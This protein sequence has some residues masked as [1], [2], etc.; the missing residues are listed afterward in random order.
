MIPIPQD[1]NQNPL[2]GQANYVA[3]APNLLDPRP[4]NVQLVRAIVE[5]DGTVTADLRW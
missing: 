5:D 3:P 4:M 2:L 1:P